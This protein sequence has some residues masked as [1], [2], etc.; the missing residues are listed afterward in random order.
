MN[1]DAAL[2][3]AARQALVSEIREHTRREL[4]DVGLRLANSLARRFAAT[5]EGGEGGSVAAPGLEEALSRDA[6]LPALAFA[7]RFAGELPP[8]VQPPLP[9]HPLLR[10]EAIARPRQHAGLL[11]D[12]LLLACLPEAH[13]GFATLCRLVHPEGLPLPTGALALHWLESEGVGQGHGVPFAVRDAV[14]DLLHYSPLAAMGLVR[15]P[16]SGPWQ[17]R[18]L[19]AGPGVWEA[20]M[21]RPPQLDNGQ[22]LSGYVQVPGLDDWLAL[23]AVTQ[24]VAALRRGLPCQVM[25]VGGDAAMRVTRVRALL[26]A[27]T[28]VAIRTQ[29]DHAGGVEA[30]SHR[31]SVD[32]YTAAFMHQACLWLEARRDEAPGDQTGEAMDSGVSTALAD[33]PEL[34][35]ITSAH[36]ERQVP[37]L[38][39]ALIRLSVQ[40]L[41]PV[42]RRRLW[43]SLLPQ[44]GEQAGELAARYP[45]EPDDAR[46]VVRD[47]GMHQ[48]LTQQALALEQV[49]ECIRARTTWSSR[50]G[51]QRVL[52][53][54][55]WSALLLPEP[56]R[57]QL[58]HAVQRV[59][60]QITVLDDWGF[61]QGRG[62]R[63]GVRML[64]F[65]TPGTGKTLAAEVV[66]RALGVDMLVVDLANLVSKWIGETEKNLAAVFDIAE[67]SRALLLFDEADALFARRTETQDAHDR[68]ANLETAYLLQRLERYEGVAVLT[69]NLRSNLDSAFA[70]RFEF[71]VEFPEPD[72]AT[73][74]ALWRLHLPAGA[75]LAE[76]V[77]LPELAAWYALSGAQIKNAALA[78]AFL[79]AAGGREI[80]QH[81]FL[82]AVENEF[83]KA[84]RA[85]PGFPP[86][87]VWPADD[88]ADDLVP[89]P[90]NGHDLS[91]HPR[92]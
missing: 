63:R 34:P 20:L 81:H 44:L 72:A 65:G 84:G 88:F 26:G 16:G 10:L 46:D 62:E 18:G 19:R 23:P 70:R 77:G 7:E 4:A 8:A 90:A 41:A 28:V 50:P 56:A 51:I 53:R 6:L 66:A 2:Q 15:L 52:P 31:Q 11:K 27:A 61:A 86:H 58:Q 64:F 30:G 78:A 12:L 60:Q 32:G 47:L 89:T 21:A 71:I 76:D 3:W 92:R 55:G 5:G 48:S 25:L 29:V 75:P 24:A 68:Y 13:E 17:G 45:I 83:D 74:E 36:S 1:D 14:E 38:G 80:H 37:L 79:A 49:G 85:H 59:L 42:A 43:Q 87:T 69:T 40:P 33:L 22:L 35:V 9:A 57:R 39:L 54:A 67:R 91:R 73:R 82:L